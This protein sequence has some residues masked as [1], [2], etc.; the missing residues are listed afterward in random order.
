[1]L[2]FGNAAAFEMHVDPPGGDAQRPSSAG[3]VCAGMWIWDHHDKSGSE[4]GGMDG[5]QG[6][7]AVTQAHE[8]PG[9]ADAQRA[10]EEGP[11][12]ETPLPSGRSDGLRSAGN[13]RRSSV[14]E[15]TQSTRP[16]EAMDS[17]LRC[18][19]PD[20]AKDEPR[21]LQS[22]SNTENTTS[23]RLVRGLP[24]KSPGNLLLVGCVPSRGE[25]AMRETS[26]PRGSRRRLGHRSSEPA[27][28][29]QMDARENNTV[30]SKKQVSCE[31]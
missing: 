29:S 28:R 4:A 10:G 20:L 14:T 15:A 1:M 26:S 9:V 8:D 12:E 30:M 13:S 18:R 25:T 16:T 11:P 19:R 24:V 21:C 22:L 2:G 27:G 7:C 17:N 6:D 23:Q 3:T 31:F 5:T